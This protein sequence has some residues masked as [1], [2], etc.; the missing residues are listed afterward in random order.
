MANI[1][2]VEDDENISTLVAHSLKKAG[3]EVKIA[4]DGIQAMNLAR[5]FQPALVV[6][7]F[8]FPAGGGASFHK[9]IRQSA[10][11]SK[12]P[13]LLLTAA[14]EDQVMQAIGGD[15]ITAFLG[16]PFNRDAL[17]QKVAEMLGGAPPQ[18]TPPGH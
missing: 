18:L 1:L 10:H 11:T 13:I 15:P 9:R 8:M 2:I 7:D 3:H 12:T 16:K 6:L 5:Q 14:P 17:L 4:I